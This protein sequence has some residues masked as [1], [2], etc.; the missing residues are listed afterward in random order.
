MVWSEIYH[1]SFF[2]TH[3]LLYLAKHGFT[4]SSME[5]KKLRTHLPCAY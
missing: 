2:Y 3:N 4:T 1:I 5:T